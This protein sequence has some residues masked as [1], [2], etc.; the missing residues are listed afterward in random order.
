M[1]ETPIGA[2]KVAPKV[3]KEIQSPVNANARDVAPP[4]ITAQTLEQSARARGETPPFVPVQPGEDD[5][6]A[7]SFVRVGTAENAQAYANITS[8]ANP[9][10]K[11][12]ASKA[13]YALK[14]REVFDK[15]RTEWSENRRALA[16]SVPAGPMGILPM[17]AP[18]KEPTLHPLTG[19]LTSFGRTDVEIV[20]GIAKAQLRADFYAK[21]YAQQGVGTLIDRDDSLLSAPDALFDAMKNASMFRTKEEENFFKAGY[22]NK[23]SAQYETSPY[24]MIQRAYRAKFKGTMH[25]SQLKVNIDEYGFKLNPKNPEHKKLFR[26]FL[27][28]ED[29]HPDPDGI[30]ARFGK[31]FSSTVGHLADAVGNAVYTGVSSVGYPEIKWSGDFKDEAAKQSLE[32]KL[33]ILASARN[34]GEVLE[35]FTEESAMSMVATKFTKEGIVDMDLLDE[36]TKKQIPSLIIDVAKE[37]KELDEKGAFDKDVRGLTSLL[38]FFSAAVTGGIGMSM[39]GVN[40]DPRS[41]TMRL[42]NSVAATGE[43]LGTLRLGDISSIYEEWQMEGMNTG[44]GYAKWHHHLAKDGIFG[45][46]VIDSRWHEGGSAFLTPFE[47]YALVSGT[48]SAGKTLFGVGGRNAGKSFLQRV[49]LQESLDATLHNINTLARQGVHLD[50]FPPDVRSMIEGIQRD[51]VSANE[52]IDVYEAVRRAFEGKGKMLDPKNPSRLVPASEELLNSLSTSITEKAKTVQTMRDKILEA[53]NAGKKVQYSKTAMDTVA[54]ARQEFKNIFPETDWTKVPDSVIYDR[55]RRGEMPIGAN[56]KPILT[57]NELNALTRE[58]GRGWRRIDAKD[59]VGYRSGAQL[60]VQFNFVYDNPLSNATIGL[61]KGVGRGSEWLDNLEKTYGSP[62]SSLTAAFKVSG[63]QGV[64]VSTLQS[65]QPGLAKWAIVNSLLYL[66]KGIGALGRYAEI[67]KEYAIKSN[68]AGVDFDS[69]FLGIRADTQAEMRQLL[70]K[71]ASI[72][73]G[74]WPIIKKQ[75]EGLG[76]NVVRNEPELVSTSVNVEKEI[77]KIDLRLDYLEAKA[78]EIKRMHALGSAGLAS[79]SMKMFRDGM[80]AIGSNEL[81]L[82]LTDNFA[83]I[84]GG[85]AYAGFGTG[86]N[87]IKSG[88]TAHFS[89]SNNLKERTNYDMGSI[90]TFMDGLGHDPSGDVQRMKIVKVMMKARDDADAIT[91]KSGENAGETYFAKQ[92]FTLAQVFRSNAELVLTNGGVRNGLIA[93]MESVQHQDPEFADAVKKQYL[94]TSLKLGLSG[95]EAEAY[96]EKMKSGLMENAAGRVRLGTLDK[97]LDLLETEHQVISDNTLAELNTLEAASKVIAAE[98]GLNTEDLFP[99]GFKIELERKKTPKDKT[100]PEG[101]PPYGI[102]YDK[103]LPEWTVKSTSVAGIDTSKMSPDVGKK[104]VAFQQEFQRIRNLQLEAHNKQTEIRKQIDAVKLD[105]ASILMKQSIPVFRDGQVTVDP[106]DGAVVT[107]FKNGITIWDRNGKKTIYLDDTAFSTSVSREEIAHALFYAENMA[108]SRAALRNMI[109][110]EYGV[111]STG[112]AVMIHGPKIAKTIEGSF[113][114]MDMF[115]KAHAETL[116]ESEGIMF[117]ASWEIGKKNFARN[118]NDTRL[119]QQTLL[120]FAGRLYQARLENANPHFGRTEAMASTPQGNIE[121]GTV[122][123]R[124]KEDFESGAKES[125]LSKTKSAARLFFKLVAGSLTIEDL[126]NDGN[127]IN[128]TDIDFTGTN[129]NAV[130]GLKERIVDATMFLKS[131]GANGVLEGMWKGMVEDKLTDFGFVPTGNN[132]P[133]FE[134]LYKYGTIRHPLTNEIIPIGPHEW[135]WASQMLAHTRNRATKTDVEA[136]WDLDTIE[137]E[138]SNTSEEAKKRRW[139]WALA[140]G[141]EAFINTETGMFKKSLTA[142]MTAE[143]APIGKLVQRIVAPLPGDDFGLTVK[144]TLDGKTV[145]VG[146]PNAQQVK[147]IVEHIKS[148]YGKGTQANEVTIKNIVTLL[149]AIADG[150][151]KDPKA[152]PT[153]KGGFPGWTQTFLAEYSPVTHRVEIGST[154]KQM[155]Y[156]ED[157]TLRMLVPLR[158]IIKDS[159]LDVVGKKRK[160]GEDPLGRETDDPNLPEMYIQMWS[161]ARANLA[162]LNAWGGNLFDADGTPYWK[163]KEIQDL[164]KTRKNLNDAMD[165]VLA[166]YQKGGSVDKVKGGELAE[167]PPHHSWEVLLPMAKKNPGNAKKMANMINRIMGF[168]QTQFVE[169][170]GLEQQQVKLT[171]AQRAK[172]EELR[173]KFDPEN[174]DEGA[175]SLDSISAREKRLAI[176]YG[177][178]PNPFG[179][180]P[181]RDAQHPLSEYRIDRFGEIIPHQNANGENQFVRWNQFTE[182]WGNANYSSENWTP[183]A[184]DI[185]TQKTKEYNMAGKK[186]VSGVTH[187]S[188]YT[189]FVLEDPLVHDI[190]DVPTREIFMIDPN[191]KLVGRGYKDRQSAIADAEQH[192]QNASLPP[193]QNNAVEQALMTAGWRPVGTAFAGGIRDKFVDSSGMYRIERSGK[194]G[195]KGFDLIDINTGLVLAEQLKAGFG[196]DKKTPNIDDVTESIKWAKENNIVQI[197]LSEA[198]EASL[199]EVPNLPQWTLVNNGTGSNNKQLFAAKNPVYYDIRKRLA[200]DIGWKTTNQITEIMRQELGDDV[201]G[202]SHKAVVEWFERWQE[203]WGPEQVRQ[204]AVD[205]SKKN[206]AEID[207]IEKEAQ[208]LYNLRQG[209][210]L[211]WNKPKQPNKPKPSGDP[212]K[213]ANNSEIFKQ[214]MNDY[215][216]E[217]LAWDSRQEELNAGHNLDEGKILSIMKYIKGLK[218]KESEFARMADLTAVPDSVFNAQRA[219]GAVDALTFINNSARE[220]AIAAESTWYINNGGFILQQLMYKDGGKGYGINITG[221]KVLVQGAKGQE[222]KEANFILYAP[223]GQ[224]LLRAK[225]AEEAADEVHRRTEGRA[226]LEMVK[227]MPQEGPKQTGTPKGPVTPSRAS[228]VGPDSRYTKPAP[229]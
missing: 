188:G 111:D 141:R 134:K 2:P 196:T 56:G 86:V 15:R 54:K 100:K 147:R 106:I 37:I 81:L 89:R 57:A 123:S 34:N 195:Y 103:F 164:F 28:W 12:I 117:K 166:N 122:T 173:E 23:Y 83:G 159:S 9:D 138:E 73:R 18:G 158:V 87:S 193:E 229:R 172:R 88:W 222:V 78:D 224:I 96:A 216:E 215:T 227:R 39:M 181:M 200:Q 179:T 127:P 38:T 155:V 219:K 209:E 163:A 95:K 62:R 162:K 183:L 102:P 143:W 92:M 53:A 46:G 206:I 116:S 120:E 99:T 79:G 69:A 197:K 201:V 136:L 50:V 125:N 208:K 65:A 149:N 121:G 27:K 71:R 174:E 40:S 91:A 175:I 146:A 176:L 203:N 204:M 118:P 98:A 36:D 13:Q 131:F 10:G 124:I 153:A 156:G 182:G 130:V 150:N 191:R 228:M 21:R 51:A 199:K 1:A 202:T 7:P 220:A 114:L 35:G 59:I 108:D 205:A 214:Q 16:T 152:T 119:M 213:D 6:V 33:L 72:T 41:F 160:P 8:D 154:K 177:K 104:V 132:S 137:R 129:R 24:Q 75:L 192:S 189:M 110:G 171:A 142:M 226:L 161:P 148:N 19:F 113:R 140:S 198:Y 151:W 107:S 90:R 185:I 45:S 167:P 63:S 61:F 80:V 133:D 77:K 3:P 44:A 42:N 47:G 93:V 31:N 20:S 97:Q 217:A 212:E 115:V 49:G 187:R 128:A 168:H 101:E 180:N 135:S 66:G 109:L 55:L 190:N 5:F 184:P 58:V 84:G 26:E 29:N 126:V 221:K 139:Q 144:K 4:M 43:A 74:Q 186:L 52:K 178:N 211:K 30:V 67:A 218:E 165:L 85:T 64:S 210:E 70:I 105:K 22:G 14:D 32:K 225:T 48:V 169:L 207:A 170:N 11:R 112:K 60:P 194:R 157:T 145:M 223:G 17:V 25:P 76:E 94:D 82:G 68:M